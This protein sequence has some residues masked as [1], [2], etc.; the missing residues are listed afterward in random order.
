MRGRTGGGFS[1]EASTNLVVQ[2]HAINS[3]CTL[4]QQTSGSTMKLDFRLLRHRKV[5]S[6]RSPPYA[7][8]TFNNAPIGASPL[9]SV[10]YVCDSVFIACGKWAHV[11]NS[12]T[13]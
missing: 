11:Y 12:D 1:D 7:R 3:F 6:F 9:I 10:G 2:C 13:R 8:I 4:W 5:E